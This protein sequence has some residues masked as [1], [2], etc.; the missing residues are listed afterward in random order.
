RLTERPP[1]A[2]A[3]R[4]RSAA[5][6]DTSGSGGAAQ[7]GRAGPG[8]GGARPR[9]AGKAGAAGV[10]GGPGHPE[11]DPGDPEAVARAICLRLLSVSA[12][13]RAG[14]EA[15]LARK[16]IPADAAARVL[17]RLTDVG[18]IDDAAYAQSF[19]ASRH[20]HGALGATALRDELRRKGVDPQTASSAVAVVDRDA[21]AERARAFLDRRVDAAM[22]HGPETARRRLL[23]LL[24]R[25]GYPA[26]LAQRVV[27][28]V[29]ADWDAGAQN[30]AGSDTDGDRP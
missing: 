20:R 30:G 23:G 24:A 10:D 4:G 25:R 15:A 13:P 19:V 9:S 28:E 16:G 8:G 21:E 2:G 14:L 1:P 27:R 5:A 7:A 3:G 6:G 18:L 17:D 26:D 22:A 12:R 29:M 11:D